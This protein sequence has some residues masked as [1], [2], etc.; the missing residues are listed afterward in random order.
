MIPRNGS[1]QTV[2]INLF[3]FVGVG[4]LSICKSPKPIDINSQRSTVNRQQSTVNRQTIPRIFIL[5]A[6]NKDIFA[7]K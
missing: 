6:V 2:N 5:L 1:T 4:R 7:K 3:T